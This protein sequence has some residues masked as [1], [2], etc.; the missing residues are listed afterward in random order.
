MS[1]AADD[2]EEDG[3]A[4]GDNAEDYEEEGEMDHDSDL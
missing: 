1:A 3:R 4:E 2:E